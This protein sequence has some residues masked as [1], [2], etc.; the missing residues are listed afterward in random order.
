MTIRSLRISE[1]AACLDLWTLVFDE[2]PRSYFQRYFQDPHWQLDDTVVCEEAGQLVSVVH[3][4]RRTV[5]T[6]DGR[7]NLAGI[8]NVAT[9]PEW[10]G[11][12]R[13][14]A[15]LTELQ[16]RIDADPWFDFALLGTDSFDFYARLGWERCGFYGWEGSGPFETFTDPLFADSLQPAKQPDLARIRAW[17]EQT[18][19]GVPLAVVRDEAYWLDWIGTRTDLS[20]WMV[21]REGYVHLQYNEDDNALELHERGGNPALHTLLARAPH[22]RLLYPCSRA[23]AERLLKDPQPYPIPWWMVRS[24]QSKPLPD[25]TGAGFLEADGF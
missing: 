15:C 6:R 5:E 16:N 18:H 17:Y 23:E 20:G 3:V 7:K 12:G 24:V 11:L 8:A 13:A 22:V 4:V 9:H 10:R 21:S 19:R 14:T 1:R 2:D 25:L